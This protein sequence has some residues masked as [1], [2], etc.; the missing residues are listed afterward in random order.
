MS[1]NIA[2]SFI[3][4]HCSVGRLPGISRTSKSLE[5]SDY[6]EGYETLTN[7]G[8]ANW[9]T[10]SKGEAFTENEL[11][12][13]FFHHYGE[14]VHGQPQSSVGLADNKK[15]FTKEIRAL[16]LEHRQW[17]EIAAAEIVRRYEWE[18]LELRRRAFRHT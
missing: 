9:A 3:S 12:A 7:Y 10:N 15:A 4:L 16:A 13:I 14:R 1:L 6:L 2:E 17:V 11:E 8:I 18:A 5:H